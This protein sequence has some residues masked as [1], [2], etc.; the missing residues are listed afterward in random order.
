MTYATEDELLQLV[1]DLVSD[2]GN[3]KK[4]AENWGISDAYLSDILAG[5]RKISQQFAHKIGFKRQ[6]VYFLRRRPTR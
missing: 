5:R 2:F 6:V 3:Q 4:A 1:R